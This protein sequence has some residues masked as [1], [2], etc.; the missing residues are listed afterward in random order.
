MLPKSLNRIISRGIVSTMDQSEVNRLKRINI[1][2]SILSILL[3]ISILFALIFWQPLTL[4]RD[5][6]ALAGTLLIYFLV[7]PGK[8]PDLNSTLGLIVVALLFLS[9][10]LVDS[11]M[12]SSLVLA[13][14]LIFPLAAGSINSK[15]GILISLIL[16]LV[17]V[18]INSVPGIQNHIHL[19]LIDAIVFMVCYGMIIA[20]SHHIEV[21]NRLLVEKLNDSRSQ[22]KEQLTERD[23]FMSKLSHKL[24]TS[25]S[26]ITLINNLVHDSRLT[27][28]QKE[29][30]ETLQASTNNLID[31]VNNI[32][33]IV[34]PEIL[35]YKKSII[36]FDLS[37]VLEEAVEII[38]S[39]ASS[40]GD[41]DMEYSGQ[42]DQL[43]IGD[44]S[45]LRSLLINIIKGLSFY[46]QADRPVKVRVRMLRETPSQVRL[47]F[48][49][50]IRTELGNTLIS[51]LDDLKSGQSQKGSNL[52]TAYRL[53]LDSE[54]ELTVALE[55]YGATISFFQD[56]AKDASRIVSDLEGGAPRKEK[57]TRKAVLLEEA[58][59]LLVEDNE[60]NQK[61]VLLSLNKKVKQIDVAGNGKIALEMF[62]LKQYDIILMDIMMPVMDGL[63]ATKKI[64]EIES[65]N[66]S[67]IPIIT[68]TA[69]ALTGDRD[70]CL[71]AGA[72]DYISKPFQAEM[73][74]RKMKNLLA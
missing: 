72:D 12:H 6:G 60:I 67:H 40:F 21:S 63:T 54:S 45:L 46:V 33:E 11:N 38:S 57:Q 59:V 47:E 71:A 56:F 51:Y 39:G 53:L 20:I 15:N 19:K 55:Q 36:S 49:F 34:S 28:Q 2:Y 14:Y 68:I 65:T 24:R 32:V 35:D 13:F 41:V 62:G 52:H 23:E 43:L 74:V 73:L 26:N 1:F 42:K 31:D 37:R 3:S 50:S 4:V 48:R 44:P 29:L 5:G 18:I 66:K 7:P 64:R 16:G 17:L 30:M 69:N 58:R 22:L 25:L 27:S 70:N 9:A 8:K 10:F 61:I